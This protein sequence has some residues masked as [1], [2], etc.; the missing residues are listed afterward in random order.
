MLA[1]WTFAKSPLGKF[2]G[3]AIAVMIIAGVAFHKG[4]G[5][6]RAKS[7]RAT[8]EAMK[9]RD[10]ID[11]NISGLDDVKLCVLAGGLPDECEQLR[12]V[13]AEQPEAG[14]GAIDNRD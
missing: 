3:L 4:R 1:L 10:R 9:K 2:A 13:E 12:R 7:L 5:F 11:E 14:N 6:E 8:V